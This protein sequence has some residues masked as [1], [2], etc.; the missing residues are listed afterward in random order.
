VKPPKP[1]PTAPPF[2]SFW[3]PTFRRP[4]SLAACIASVGRQTAA[5][6]CEQFVLPDHIGLGLV[7][8]LYG[9]MRWYYEAFRGKYVHVL[10]DDDELAAEDVVEKLMKFAEKKGE[11]PV[12]LVR[13][14]KGGLDLPF[15]VPVPGQRWDPVCG[16]IDLSCYVLRQDIWRRHVDDYGNRYEGDYDHA[17]ALQ[18]AGHRLE[19]LDLQFVDGGASNGRPEVDYR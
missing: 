12:I 14:T 19:F 3:T 17:V 7:N 13:A 5:E 18:N 2:I 11:P 10:C 6:H 4:K 8:G 15:Q 1:M 16:Q 9:R